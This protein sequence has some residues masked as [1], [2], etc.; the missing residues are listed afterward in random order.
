M[1]GSIPILF[2]GFSKST[3]DN[4]I[5]ELSY[6]VYLLHILV[7][8]V[9]GIALHIHHPL[10]VAA[11]TVIFALGLVRFVEEPVNRYR[12]LRH[13]R[14]VGDIS[15]AATALSSTEMPVL[16]TSTRITP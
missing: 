6:P 5:G 9:L 3:W 2:A 1:I 10:I 14:A 4:A 16:A 8:G 15:T 12:Q 7:G 11:V 13:R